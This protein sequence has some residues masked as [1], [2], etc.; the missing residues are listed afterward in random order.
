MSKEIVLY[1]EPCEK[2]PDG[3]KILP[4]KWE[5][6]PQCHGEGKSSAYLGSFTYAEFDERFETLEEQDYYFNGGYDKTCGH[7]Q[8]T[9]KVRVLDE[10]RCTPEELEEYRFQE[11]WR[12]SGEAEAEAER[13]F[14]A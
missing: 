8:G 9:G 3:E 4:T 6:C 14:G 2:Y 1:V 13:R 5:I 11:F 7:C 10:S 12:R